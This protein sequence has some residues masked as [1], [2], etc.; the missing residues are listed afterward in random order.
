VK[1]KKSPER[2]SIRKRNLEG[3][4]KRARCS[5]GGPDGS[6]TIRGKTQTDQ[7]KKV[8]L[9]KIFEEHRTRKGRQEGASRGWEKKQYQRKKREIKT[10]KR[11]KKRS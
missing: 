11:E 8:D 5:G 4:A 6:V 10:Q 1:N 7:K 9:R 3:L 2:G